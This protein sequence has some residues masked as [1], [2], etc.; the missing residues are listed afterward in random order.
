MMDTSPVD[1]ER[2]IEDHKDLVYHLIHRTVRDRELHEE[3]FQE[4]FMNVLRSLPLFEGRSKLSTWIASIAVHTC[5]QFIHKARKQ[6]QVESFETW[7][8]RWPE[9]NVSSD[10][11]EEYERN[12]VRRRLEHHL[13]N[14]APKYALPIILFY[15]EGL[16]YKEIAEVLN[17][18]LGTVKSHLFR[19]LAE[20]K[21]MIDGGNDEHLHG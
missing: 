6:E 15:L 3:I 14:L 17:I 18:P 16:S 1:V 4:V 10:I 19:G 11:Q 5:Y 12:Q 9:P 21:K 7:L 20:L 2:L 8:E 13:Q